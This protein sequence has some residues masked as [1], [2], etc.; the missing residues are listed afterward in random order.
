MVAGELIVENAL[1]AFDDDLGAPVMSSKV[2][3]FLTR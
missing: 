1:L 2:T 3:S